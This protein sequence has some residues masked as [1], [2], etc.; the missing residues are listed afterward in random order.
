M[1][2]TIFTPRFRQ[3]RS[4]FGQISVSIMMKT[5]GLTMFERPPDDERPVERKIEHRVHVMQAA[6]R[7]FL[8]RHG[9]GGQEQA[10]ARIAGLEVLGEGPR[11]QRLANR[12]RVDP[13]R[14]LAVDVEGNRQVTEALAE[15]ADVLLV[16][17][18]LVHEVRRHDDEENQRQQAV[19]EVHCGELL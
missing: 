13:D 6:A 7:H 4:R 10:Q 17:D 5:R 14:F 12:H 16:A 9:R 2:T 15:A 18:R 8:P 3:T 1:I 19:R 11:G